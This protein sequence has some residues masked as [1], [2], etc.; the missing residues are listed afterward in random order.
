MQRRILRAAGL[1]LLVLLVLLVSILHTRPARARIL[2]ELVAVVHKAIRLDASVQDVR[3]DFFPPAVRA[4]GVRLSHPTEGL[5]ARAGEVTVAPRLLPALFGK[6]EIGEIT[7]DSADVRLVVRDGRIVNI[8][9]L[10][11]TGEIES[12]DELPFGDLALSDSHLLVEAPGWGR[13]D[14]GGID[15][16][17]LV[18]GRR[19]ILFRLVAL[20]GEVAHAKGVEKLRRVEL[21]AGLLLGLAQLHRLVLETTDARIRISDGMLP[22][23]YDGTFAAR[24]SLD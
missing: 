22:V 9:V 13:A 18:E 5:L 20:S 2:R 6:L 19:D 14:L 7:V 17:V 1:T 15:L 3:L 12:A 11:K 23:P 24:V 16:D 8:P 10:R 21:R 4:I